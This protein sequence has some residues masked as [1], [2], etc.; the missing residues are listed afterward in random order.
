MYQSNFPPHSSFLPHLGW[1]GRGVYRE[2]QPP[3]QEWGG[4]C[5]EQEQE[6]GQVP[7]KS[8]SASPKQQNLEA[9]CQPAVVG[10]FLAERKRER[11]RK[12]NVKTSTRDAREPKATWQLK[13]RKTK[14]TQ[15]SLPG[16]VL[17][18]TISEA[19]TINR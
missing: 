6:L 10:R 14:A 9:R 8:A 17:A 13:L 4:G 19:K 7:F 5:G 1:Y 2:V 3:I 18:S 11:E 16:P 12:K 15:V